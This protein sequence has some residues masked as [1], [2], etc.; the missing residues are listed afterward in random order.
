MAGSEW[1]VEM[2][3]VVVR[4]DHMVKE[5]EGFKE[6]ISVDIRK[7]NVPSREIG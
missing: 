6:I 5:V 7:K 3:N 4:V 1:Q 2:L